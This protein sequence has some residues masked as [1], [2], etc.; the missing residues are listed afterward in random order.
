MNIRDIIDNTHMCNYVRN[1]DL[2]ELTGWVVIIDT[3]L[4]LLDEN[5]IDPY[6]ES[7]K[8]RISD[9]L[10]AYPIRDMISPLGGGKSFVFHRAKVI[11][12]LQ[13]N[14]DLQ[15]KVQDL[16]IENDRSEFIHIDVGDD[17]IKRARKKYGD[18]LMQHDL[19]KSSD[20]L[21]YF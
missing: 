12:L 13:N 5:L 6:I 16:F 3:Q 11:G 20:W 19:I 17:A 7:K 14:P 21:D 1:G 15:I 2:V 9:P 4:F 10:I 18:F 8:I